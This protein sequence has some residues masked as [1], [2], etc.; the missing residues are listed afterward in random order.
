VFIIS[1]EEVRGCNTDDVI[2]VNGRRQGAVALALAQFPVVP[3]RKILIMV[4]CRLVGP[5]HM[6][7][8][9]KYLRLNA[10]LLQNNTNMCDV[11]VF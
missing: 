7:H 1:N 4:T 9:P 3:P 2:C 10:I 6:L 5:N 11:L 8:M